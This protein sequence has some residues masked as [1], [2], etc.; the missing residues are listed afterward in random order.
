MLPDRG[1]GPGAGHVRAAALGVH[2]GPAVRRHDRFAAEHVALD[3]ARRRRVINRQRAQDRD[4]VGGSLRL[5]GR[6]ADEVRV[7]ERGP[8]HA[9]L[10]QVEIELQ[11]RAVGS[12]A[13]LEP[14]RDR[15]CADPDRDHAVGLPGG[16]QRVP[17]P[18]A[19][20]HRDVDLPAELADIA[21]PRCQRPDAIDVHRLRGQ[22]RETGVADIGIGDRREDVPCP[23]TP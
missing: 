7:L 6:A 4:G 1:S 22:E 3:P 2:D 15:V 9:R 10:D 21:D 20:L 19:L 8:G 14:G 11:F 12:V 5:V 16:P 13:L 23:G 17:D 18:E